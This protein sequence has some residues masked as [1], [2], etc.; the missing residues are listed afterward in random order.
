MN[1]KNVISLIP[2]CKLSPHGIF[3]FHLGVFK[4]IQIYVKESLSNEAKYVVRGYLKHAY[5]ADIYATFNCINFINKA[6]LAELKLNNT[7]ESECVG[8]GRI[9]IDQNKKTILVYGYS[10]GFGRCDHSKSCDIIKESYPD[11]KIDWTNEGY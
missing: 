11:Y 2:N 6:E 9:N 5:H 3:F 7:V 8:G 4:Y 1:N 10:Q